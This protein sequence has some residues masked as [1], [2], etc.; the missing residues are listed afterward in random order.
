M[1]DELFRI[2]PLS[3]SP[4]GV[5]LVLSLGLAYWQAHR[6]FRF[7]GIGDEETAS[8]L[9]FACGF[10]GIVGGKIYY[11]MLFGDWRLFFDRAG[12]VF[13][14]AFIGGLLGLLWSIHRRRLPFA[15]TFDVAAPALALGYGFGRLGCFLVGDDYGMP[16]DGP[17]GV[18]F[19]VGPT[20]STAGNLRQMFG[21]DVPASIANSEVLA[22]H[23]TQL[24]ETAAGLGIWLLALTLMRRKWRPG[25]LALTVFPLLAMA[26]FLVEFV[27]AKDDRFFGG[28]T[29]AQMIS[30]AIILVV[31]VIAWR[32]RLSPDD[33]TPET[34]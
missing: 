23:P 17:L 26:R 22:V 7:Y 1:I 21:V 4:F 19:P 12:I 34:P 6:G 29:L 27:R 31:A 8:A 32:R 24:Y 16:T 13:Y 15:R 14:G 11:A 3:I 18:K 33:P 28:F 25:S 30:L 9:T 5:M 10:A 2:G 20:P